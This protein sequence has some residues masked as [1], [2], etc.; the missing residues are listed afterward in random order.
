VVPEIFFQ[1]F[2][3]HANYRDHVIPVAFI[4]LPSKTEQIYQQMVNEIIQ[5]A[6]AWQPQRVMMDFEK[7][8]INVF[9][10]TFPA[11]ELSGCYFHFCQNVLRFLQVN[12]P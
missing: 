1:L 5:L 9:N 12:D 3:I 6:P 7:A 2:A 4:L 8:T 11:V 10:H